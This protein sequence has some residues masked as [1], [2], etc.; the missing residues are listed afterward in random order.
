MNLA[1]ENAKGST[2]KYSEKRQDFEDFFESE[3]HFLEP[4][5]VWPGMT[6]LDIGCA[7]GGLGRAL[8]NKIGKISYTGMDTDSHSIEIAKERYPDSSFKTGWF[9]EDAPREKFD[10]V[11]MLALFPQIP[12]WKK[13]LLS[14]VG[15]SRKYINFSCIIR[16]AGPTVIDK[17]TAYV[18]YFGSGQRVHQVVHNIYE[19][20]N[21]CCIRE[22]RVKKISFWGYHCTGTTS[23]R[24]LAESEQIRGNILLE[25]FETEQ[26][27]ERYAGGLPKDEV[28]DGAF[29]PELEIF[30]DGERFEV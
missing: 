23:F 19:M 7:S 11:I 20:V 29:R 6:V 24:P 3:K 15:C 13:A 30:I 8:N 17:D 14:M 4:P 5:F 21:F 1:Y 2:K 18:Y 9:P 10:L 28:T 25:L 22:M 12:E 27:V 26:D 16:L